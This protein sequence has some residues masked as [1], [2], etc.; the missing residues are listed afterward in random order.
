M[1]KVG[2]RRWRGE[3]GGDGRG[4]AWG[5]DLGRE[6]R[7]VPVKASGCGKLV[8]FPEAKQKHRGSHY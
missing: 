3:E 6:A 5:R 4:N 7:S 8:L 2:L 1:S